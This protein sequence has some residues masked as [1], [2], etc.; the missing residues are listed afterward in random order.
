MNRRF[1]TRKINLLPTGDP[2]VKRLLVDIPD[3]FHDPSDL[4]SPDRGLL[5]NDTVLL[6]PL[7]ER[8]FLRLRL[9]D[10]V[11]V[12]AGPCDCEERMQAAI[13]REELRD[14]D[15][16]DGGSNRGSS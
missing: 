7:W 6:C 14:Y 9:D 5:K 16:N 4:F 8:D 2:L 10:M 1:K 15:S 12:H 13:L 11:L 3:P